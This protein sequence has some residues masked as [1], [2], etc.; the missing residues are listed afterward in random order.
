MNSS[1][2]TAGRSPLALVLA[3]SLAIA[4]LGNWPL[5]Q[6][7]QSLGLLH[8]LVGWGLAAALLVMT[9]AALVALQSLLA[10]RWTLKPAAMLLLLAT[11]TG[12]HF[13]LAYR[14]VIDQSMLVNVLQTNPGEAADLASPRLLATLLLGAALP[15]WL[16][17]R[18]P[19]AYGRW[20]RRLLRNAGVALLA[21]AVLAL[22]LLA[23][24]QPLASTMRNHKP[25]RYLVNPLNAIYALGLVA[26]EPLRR[27]SRSLQPLGTDAHLLATAPGAKPPLLLLVVGETARAGNFALN[28]YARPTNPQLAALAQAEALLSFSNAWACGTNTAAS[29]PC[30]FSHL[31]R[32]GFNSRQADHENLLDVAQRAGLAVL[33]LDNQAGC[34]GVCARVPSVATGALTDP[35]LCSSGECHDAILLQGLD[36]RLAAL[37]AA[38]RA[39]GV[40]L[41]MHQMGSHGP[42]Y[43]KRVPA[44]AKRFLPECTSNDLQDC[45]QAQLVNA[46]DNTIAYTD[47]VLAQAVAWLKRQQ[48]S[49]DTALLYVSD[50]GESLGEHNLYLHGLPYAMA[51]DVQKRVPWITWLSPGMLQRQPLDVACLRGRA[52]LPLSHDHL[53]HSVLGLLGVATSAHQPGLDAYAPCR[54]SQPAVLARGY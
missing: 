11:A 53:F 20:P 37:P 39:R 18:M 9:T 40:L 23:G 46:Y 25:L 1:P 26:A 45:S 10:W 42:A 41:V 43:F 52:G 2:H 34:K 36:A 54:A 48:A 14:I 33:W 44:A 38:Q 21:L 3:T 8:G 6:A 17:W 27:G 29:L 5:W 16:V 50:H 31:G 49:H 15:A 7:L 12:A 13:M 22:A 51:P 19:L 4:T 32:E 30:M 35:A 24:F 47:Q 28:G